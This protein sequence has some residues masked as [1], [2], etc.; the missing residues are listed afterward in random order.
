MKTL[1]VVDVQY[2]FLP[3]GSLAVPDTDDIPDIISRLILSKKYDLVILSQ[4]WHPRRHGSFA[5]AHKAKPFT[6][7]EL[8]GQPQM[9]WPNHCV[10]WTHG[11]EIHE[12]I[13]KSLG[14][15]QVKHK[16]F[17]KGKDLNADS[18]SAFYDNNHKNS[19]GLATY[20]K[21]NKVEEIEICGLACDFCIR[22][23]ALDAVK[24]GF[25]VK[26]LL[27][28]CR[29]VSEDTTKKAIEEMKNTGI[30]IVDNLEKKSDN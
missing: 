14:K 9:M 15:T 30:E 18:Y 27:P 12:D 19:T 6:M 20:L 23:T 4:D 10:K 16:I 25:K 2:D 8:N 22:A 24:E 29:G 13:L 17:K 21:D 11:A 5:S 3:H 7:G 28:A 1:L 26:L